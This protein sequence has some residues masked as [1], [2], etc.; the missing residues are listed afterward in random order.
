LARRAVGFGG[1]ADWAWAAGGEDEGLPKP[2][3]G[4]RHDSVE[5]GACRQIAG[6]PGLESGPIQRDRGHQLQWWDRARGPRCDRIADES[7]Q[8]LDE[9]FV[10]CPE[11][12]ARIGA[13]SYMLREDVR[14]GRDD[15]RM[16]RRFQ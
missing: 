14:K 10:G 9:P 13:A 15:D 12:V 2:R 1:K 3:S 4:Y 6:F 7:L 8:V 5:H 11:A 16:R